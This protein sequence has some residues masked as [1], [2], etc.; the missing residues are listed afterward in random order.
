MLCN[1]NLAANINAVLAYVKLYPSD[2]FM[3]ILPLHHTYESTIGFLLPFAIGG[4]VAVC[5]GLKYIVPNLQ[6]TKPTA[7]LTVPLLVENLYKKINANIK[8]SKKENMVNSMIHVTNALKAVGVDIKKKV[9]NEIHENL[10]GNL[11][12]IVSAAAPIDAKIGN[13]IEDI[14]IIFYKDMA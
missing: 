9:F 1:R 13:W 14:G 6:E 8:K 4:S 3:S 11:K 5:Q 2:R 7:L 12:Y 10:G